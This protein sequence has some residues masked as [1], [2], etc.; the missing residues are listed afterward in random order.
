MPFDIKKFF[1]RSFQEFQRAGWLYNHFYFRLELRSY[2]DDLHP[3]ARS[4]K[5]AAGKAF[6]LKLV[7]VENFF[8]GKIWWLTTA[9]LAEAFRKS[10]ALMICF[11]PMILSS[12]KLR[13]KLENHYNI[14]KNLMS[15]FHCIHAFLVF[16]T[17]W[18]CLPVCWLTIAML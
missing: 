6:Y 14:L 8:S 4:F 15:Y 17:S 7:I 3:L 9:E 12:V 13:F 18:F 16:R 11:G 1:Q 10:L 5:D 2:G